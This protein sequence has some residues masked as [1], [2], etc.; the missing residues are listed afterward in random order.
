VGSYLIQVARD[1]GFA[2][3]II[4]EASKNS[5][6]ILSLEKFEPGKQY[7]WRVK[8]CADTKGEVCGNDWSEERMFHTHLLLLPTNPAPQDGEKFSLPGTLKW[9]PDD[10]ASYYQYQVRYTDLKYGEDRDGND[11][12][13]D[14]PA[15]INKLENTVIPQPGRVSPITSQPSFYLFEHCKGEYEWLVRSCADKNCEVATPTTTFWKF[16]ATKQTSEENPGLV[17]CNKTIDSTSTPFDETE[18]CQFKHVGFLLQNILDFVLFKLSLIILAVLAAFV[19][20]STYFSFGSPDVITRMR[21][22]FRSYVYGVL[23]LLFA[24]LIVNIIMAVFGFNIEFFGRWYEL[25]F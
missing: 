9:E 15:C 4:K 20:A 12:M 3:E 16:T 25:P 17:P 11:I 6:F 1:A 19:A 5:S 14:R 8:T 2:E 21:S 22:I 10:G 7:W 13:E 18:P 23:V 24:W